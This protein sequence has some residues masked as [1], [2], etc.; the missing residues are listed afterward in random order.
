M[1]D[2]LQ[3]AL[4]AARQSGDR[5]AETLAHR[6][7]GEAYADLGQS[8]LAIEHYQAAL[9]IAQAGAAR[10]DE[11]AILHVLGGVYFSLGQM[12]RA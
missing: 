8:S 7:L 10:S 9:T 11:G 12:P 3:Q 4:N 5:R 6:Q 1:L 2:D